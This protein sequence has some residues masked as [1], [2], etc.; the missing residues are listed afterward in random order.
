MIKAGERVVIHTPGG[1]GYGKPAERDRAR[2]ADDLADGLITA[3][4]AARIY[5]GDA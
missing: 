1:G 3:A 5:G 4:A 2:I